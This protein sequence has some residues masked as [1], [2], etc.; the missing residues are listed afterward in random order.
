MD[1]SSVWLNFVWKGK[2]DDSECQGNVIDTVVTMI[3]IRFIYFYFVA[4]AFFLVFVYSTSFDRFR[5]H[6][7]Y[8][9]WL[10]ALHNWWAFK[11]LSITWEKC[12]GSR[13]LNSMN[14]YFLMLNSTCRKCFVRSRNSFDFSSDFF[15]YLV[16]TYLG[17]VIAKYDHL[18]NGWRETGSCGWCKKKFTIC[19]RL[20][21][22]SAEAWHIECFPIF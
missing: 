9:Y 10:V 15:C 18:V 17:N 13:R 12:D 20:V 8:Q 4:M 16:W 1:E 2:A 7:F 19:F 14:V 22:E 3:E 11:L 5:S 6:S 21:G